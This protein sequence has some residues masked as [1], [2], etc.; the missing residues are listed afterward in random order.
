MGRIKFE[1]LPRDQ[2]IS[3]EDMRKVVGGITIDDRLG[4]FKLGGSSFTKLI[5]PFHMEMGGED[6]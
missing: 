2:K 4:S 5:N 3:K 6:E 1:D